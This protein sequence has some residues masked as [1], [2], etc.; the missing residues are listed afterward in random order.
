MNLTD[1]RT[2]KV[3]KKVQKGNFFVIQLI[4]ILVNTHMHHDSDKSPR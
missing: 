2:D 4:V 1:G 3:I